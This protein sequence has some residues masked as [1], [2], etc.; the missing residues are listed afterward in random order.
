MTGFPQISFREERL[1]NGLQVLL[2]R[3]NRVPLVHVGVQYRVGSSHEK[4]GFSG[5][6]HLFEHMMFQGSENVAKNE[7]GKRVDSAGGSWNATTNKDRTNYFETIPSYYLDLALWLET[8]R[9]RSLRVTAENFE[10]QRNTV[11]EEKKQNYDNRPYGLAHLRFDALAYSNWAYGHPIIGAVEDLQNASWKDARD[12]HQTFYSPHRATL[13]VSGDIQEDSTLS[14]IRKHFESIP[15]KGSPSEPDLSEP[16][17]DEERFESMRDPLAALPALSAGFLMGR[18]G[19]TDY[20]A[21]S[22]LGI[23]LSHGESSRLYR[24]FI[25]DQNLATA[26]TAGPN[27]YKGPELFNIWMQLQS[28]VDPQEALRVLEAELEK[29]R[30]ELVTEQELQKARNQLAFH[31]VNRLSTVAGIGEWLARFAVYYDDPNRINT[32]WQRFLS[33]TAEEIRDTAAR[34]LQPNRRTALVVEAGVKSL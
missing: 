15:Q 24:R 19:S 12:F 27:Q 1:A 18:L 21:L 8:D 31:F 22:L 33:V 2:Y 23:T 30:M 29:V 26:V 14:Q 11:I 4:T 13:V 5:F 28:G 7:H 20:Y 10:N 9:M 16:E 25:H 34:V 17:R 32:D 6:A 3:D